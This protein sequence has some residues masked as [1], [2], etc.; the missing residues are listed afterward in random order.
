MQ[1]TVTKLAIAAT[2]VSAVCALGVFAPVT[3]ATGWMTL[4]G[5]GLMPSV[6]M[7]RAWRQLEQSTSECIQAEIR[8]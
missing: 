1:F 7:L 3:T 8:R 6:F 2:W 4:V 5:F